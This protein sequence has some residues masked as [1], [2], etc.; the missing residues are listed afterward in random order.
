MLVV[1]GEGGM[2]V[3]IRV[4]VVWCVS[5][6]VLVLLSWWCSCGLMLLW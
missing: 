6:L 1:V 4:R 2:V 5:L 3:V